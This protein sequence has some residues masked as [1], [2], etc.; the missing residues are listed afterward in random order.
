M[1]S[2]DDPSTPEL[3]RQ[4]VAYERVETGQ[5]KADHEA[6]CRVCEKLRLPLGTLAGGAGFRSLLSRALALAKHESPAL[7]AWEV[8]ADG[9]LHGLN[10]QAAQSSSVLVAHLIGL[11]IMLIG[12][13]LTL[14][15]IH[16]VWL[17]LP[18]S[19]PQFERTEQNE[20]A[21]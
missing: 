12:K 11:M 13:S 20:R 15:I 19:E 1:R 9:S 6:V 14:R 5:A 3:A 17:D 10:G 7:S 16:D 21:E 2:A 8:R 4:L 18:R